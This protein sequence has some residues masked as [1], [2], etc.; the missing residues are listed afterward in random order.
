MRVTVRLF[1]RLRDL[2]A[3]QQQLAHRDQ[4]VGVFRKKLE[5]LAGRGLGCGQIAVRLLGLGYAG[6][7]VG[8]IREHVASTLGVVERT[9]GAIIEELD[10]RELH[11]RIRVVRGELL[12]LFGVF[13]RL[14]KPAVSDLHRG[15]HAMTERLFRSQRQREL[16]FARR[17]MQATLLQQRVGEQ[18]VR[19]GV[20]RLAREQAL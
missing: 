6:D 4:R 14:V 9:R 15:Q 7:R 17:R 11:Q 12:R 20:L 5:R 3:T 19:D 2:T 16:C 13:A 1:A 8:V 10:R 18:R